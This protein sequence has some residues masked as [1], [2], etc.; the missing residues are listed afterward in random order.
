MKIKYDLDMP[1][2]AIQHEIRMMINKIYKLL[3]LREEDQD[4]QKALYSIIEEISGLNFLLEDDFCN[5]FFTLLCKLEG[6]KILDKEEDFY[7]QRKTIFECLSM[8]GE[9]EKNVC[10]R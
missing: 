9:L 3:P 2:F 6:L 4:W 10:I 7:I 1:S 5:T 8:L